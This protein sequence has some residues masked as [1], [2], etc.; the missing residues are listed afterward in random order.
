[1]SH[2]TQ[3]LPADHRF[4]FKPDENVQ[5][6]GCHVDVWLP[7]VSSEAAPVALFFH[8][9]GFWFGSSLLV[10]LNQVRYLL[11]HGVVV[12]SA[13]YRYRPQYVFSQGQ[14]RH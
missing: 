2:E 8:G 9:G 14:R 7:E 11:D 12:V 1:M 6:G 5:G 13:A 10:P 3:P 4:I